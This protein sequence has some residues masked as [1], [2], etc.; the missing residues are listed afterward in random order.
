MSLL[1]TI[2]Q[3]ADLRR[4]PAAQLPALAAEIRD[5]MIDKVSRT[6]GHLGPNLGVV[7]LTVALHLVFDSPSDRLLW[8][9]GHQTY[10]HKLLTGRR[11]GFDRLRQQGGLSGYPSQKESDHD[12][13]ENSHASTAL[14]YA[15]GLARAYQL[16]GIH[17]RAVVAIVG[18]GSL[19]G[20]MA[21]EA[22]NNI[23]GAPDRPV[24]VVLNDNGRSYAPTVGGIAAHMTALRSAGSGVG[25]VFEN[26]GLT[27]IGPVD[28]HDI[29]AT[30][31]AL[32][33]ARSLGRPVVVHC[34]TEK[35]RGY[36]H[37][38]QHELDRFHAVRAMDPMTAIETQASGPTWTSVFAD[39]MLAIGA[40]RPDVVAITAA[41]LEP[42]GLQ[43]FQ[44][45][46]PK[47]VF[48]VGI[49]EQHAVAAAVG[50]ALDGLHPVLAIYATFM[51][52]AFDQ[53]LTDLA[54]HQRAATFVLDR[55]GVTGEDGPS[56]NGM[57]DLS[58]LQVVP[59]IRIA[60]PRDGVRLRQ[61]LREAVAHTAGPTVVRYPKG[62]LGPNLTAV[63]EVDGVDV[64]HESATQEVLIVC[65]GPMATVGLGVAKALAG[66]GVAAT[67][68]DPRWVVPVD[69]ALVGLAAQHRLV[70]T[71]ED[72]VRVGGLGAAVAQAMRDAGVFTP[73][74]DFGIPHQFLEHG[75]RGAVLD[76]CG[77]TDRKI[78]FEVIACLA[79]LPVT[80][81]DVSPA[82]LVGAGA[83]KE[84]R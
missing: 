35:G 18:D 78:S 13:I 6:G 54:L 39:E 23:G 82:R 28:G 20:G 55:A 38:E 42:A 36:S 73:L 5:F 8:D 32:R 62:A 44:Q 69:R 52:R 41:M 40:D 30:E 1:E 48:D 66:Q 43:R 75:S 3:P 49:A 57:W 70:V 14:S 11:E 17:D 77:L 56:H 12:I 80:D 34:V 50:L 4:L 10:V 76:N 84:S 83:G 51:N 61:L 71:I 7:E 29:T 37:A 67:V 79:G 27:Y 60:V 63:R 31:E 16:R 19:T 45:R 53:L 64:L 26:L 46:Y 21:W 65:A 25:S 9:T 59:G 68:V 74:Q 33:R 47:R 58:V 72:N 22:L 24:I 15:D 81:V 2:D